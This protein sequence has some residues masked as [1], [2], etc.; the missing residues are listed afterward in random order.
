M[1]RSRSDLEVGEAP[2]EIGVGH[3]EDAVGEDRPVAD[4]RRAI[5]R[6][7][8]HTV[9]A[10]HDDLVRAHDVE[11]V[12]RSAEHGSAQLGEIDESLAAQRLEESHELEPCYALGIVVAAR[13][14]RAA[15]HRSSCPSPPG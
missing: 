9:G 4:R 10:A 6:L 13:K 12:D 7:L 11:Q 5:H 15:P 14:G 2:I 1:P 8:R 3:L